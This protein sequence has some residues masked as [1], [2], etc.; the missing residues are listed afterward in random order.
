MPIVHP[1][2]QTASPPPTLGNAETVSTLSRMNVAPA[3]SLLGIR[4][5]P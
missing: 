1:I 4:R 2:Q 5:V 3:W